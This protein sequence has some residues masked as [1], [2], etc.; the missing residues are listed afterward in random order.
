MEECTLQQGRAQGRVQA[1]VAIIEIPSLR[2]FLVVRRQQNANDHWSG[3]YAFPGGRINKDDNSPLAAAIR[4][5]EEEIG[6]VLQ[7][8]DL[9]AP[10][11]IAPAGRSRKVP[12]FVQPFHFQLQKKPPLSLQKEE[13]QTALWINIDDFCKQDGHA[14][15]E[16]VP[17]HLPGKLY[18]SWPLGDY[19]LWGFTYEL[20]VT[21][22]GGKELTVPVEP[23]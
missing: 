8:E 7:Q 21:V 6:V 1:A 2:Q 14:M 9:V 11:A 18:P 4:E 17:G 3:H 10:L 19:Y 12:T 5:T 23:E 22:F 15:R 16:M 13:I 20:A